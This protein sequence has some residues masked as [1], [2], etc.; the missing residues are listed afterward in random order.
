V[1]VSRG[2]VLVV[3]DEPAVCHLAARVLK[4]RGFKVLEALDAIGA[5]EMVKA[6]RGNIQ[7]LLTDLVLPGM[8]GDELARTLQEE[9]PD[10]RVVF[11]SGYEEHELSGLG[12]GTLGGAYMTKPFNADV[13]TLMVEGAIE[14]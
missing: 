1:A 13:L 11:M 5:I 6:V 10:L 8:S 3:D 2:V 14:A 9:N 12:L 4:R 7:L